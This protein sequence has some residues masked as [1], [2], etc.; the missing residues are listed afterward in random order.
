MFNL[1]ANVNSIIE[2]DIKKAEDA[3]IVTSTKWG[4]QMVEI[5]QFKADLREHLIQQY[6]KNKTTINPIIDTI[7]EDNCNIKPIMEKSIVDQFHV[8][9]FS[10]PNINRKF[11]EF[12]LNL[13]VKSV[14]M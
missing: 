3:Y 11:N 10:K 12:M 1:P 2:A 5:D 9:S 7:I 4:D 6:I 8:D 14:S 13:I